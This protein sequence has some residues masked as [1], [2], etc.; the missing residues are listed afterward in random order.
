MGGNRWSCDL[1]PDHRSSDQGKAGSP[2]PRPESLLLT[3][4]IAVSCSATSLGGKVRMVHFPS[5]PRCSVVTD[6]GKL[7]A[8]AE[9][10]S[11]LVGA[12]IRA[13][14]LGGSTSTA[15]PGAEVEVGSCSM[16]GGV[17]GGVTGSST[18]TDGP[19]SSPGE[20]PFS[21]S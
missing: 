8:G 15:G 2:L 4:S 19:G 16:S 5:L 7:G 1:H 12:K 14:G 9:A 10:S 18:G 17:D 21:G 3:K 20:G 6:R 11:V 13:G